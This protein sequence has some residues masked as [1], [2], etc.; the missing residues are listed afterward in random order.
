MRFHQRARSFIVKACTHNRRTNCRHPHDLR[1]Y[2]QHRET[3]HTLHM[4]G[5]HRQDTY[6]VYTYAYVSIENIH[7][8]ITRHICT[9]AQPTQTSHM[10]Y[11]NTPCTLHIYST[12][13]PPGTTH[14]ITHIAHIHHTCAHTHTSYHTKTPHTQ[15]RPSSLSLAYGFSCAVGEQPHGGSVL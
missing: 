7:V 14:S 4:H 2:T 9:Y 3:I 11:R 8:H 12:P 15:S 6:H 5:V 10:K 13:K 1:E